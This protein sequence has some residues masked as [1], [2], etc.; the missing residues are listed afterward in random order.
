MIHKHT[1]CFV[2][3]K[4]YLG[5]EDGRRGKPHRERSAST[6]S[7]AQGSLSMRTRLIRVQLLDG[8]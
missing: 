6:V 2:E 5:L 1:H 4:I 3:S 7:T 8:L